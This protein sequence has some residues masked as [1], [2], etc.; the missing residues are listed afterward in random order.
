MIRD[1]E[2]VQLDNIART[3]MANENANCHVAIHYDST[4]SD[5][6]AF[7]ISR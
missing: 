1:S 4:E 3:V 7:F 6:G 2:D 5:K